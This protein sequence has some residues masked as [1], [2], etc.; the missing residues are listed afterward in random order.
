MFKFL[1]RIWEIVSFPFRWLGNLIAR[2]FRAIY[3]FMMTEP[4]S[5]PIGD[6]L[7]S[8][9]QEEDARQQL[10]DDIEKFRGHLLRSVAC[11]FLVAGAVAFYANQITEFLA[12]PVGGKSELQAIELTEGVSVY[13]KVV[14]TVALAISILYIAFE[15]WFYVA[16]G[17]SVKRRWQTLWLIPLAALLFWSGMV[18]TYFIILPPSIQILQNVGG[19]QSNPRADDY[20][21]LITR[22]LVWIGLFFEF[23][24]ITTL[25]TDAGMITPRV[26][27]SQWRLAVVVIGVIAAVITPTTDPGSMAIVMVPMVVLYFI[28]IGLS[29]LSYRDRQ[30]KLALS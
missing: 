15:F 28:S 23:P 11:I 27:L 17:L 10:I 26:L 21:S 3:R 4:A 12:T 14:F 22:L 16:P 25:L 29:F 7:A 30:K 20:Y 1:R 6:I 8:L 24:L 18:F 2:P 19:F 9:A 13:M 5:Q